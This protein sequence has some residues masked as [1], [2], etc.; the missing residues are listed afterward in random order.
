ML[1]TRLPWRSIGRPGYVK[2]PAQRKS[3]GLGKTESYIQMTQITKA[4]LR[5]MAAI[6]NV[7]S[8]FEVRKVN[9]MMFLKSNFGPARSIIAKGQFNV[10][11]QRTTSPEFAPPARSFLSAMRTLTSPRRITIRQVV[12]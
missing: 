9:I 10:R 5:K 11:G 8:I 1:K 3:T 7:T 4:M 12:A 6:F 2:N